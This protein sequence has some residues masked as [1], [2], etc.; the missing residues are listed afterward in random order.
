MAVTAKGV[1]VKKQLTATELAGLEAYGEAMQLAKAGIWDVMAEKVRQGMAALP[2]ATSGGAWDGPRW[3][4]DARKTRP[5]DTPVALFG[6]LQVERLNTAQRNLGFRSMIGVGTDKGVV[7]EVTG[8]PARKAGLQPG[9]RF[10]VIGG[11][12]ILADGAITEAIQAS[13]PGEPVALEVERA[14]KR[15]SLTVTP[16]RRVWDGRS[17]VVDVLTDYAVMASEAGHPALAMAVVDRLRQF[18]KD[19]PGVWNDE[20]MSAL[21]TGHEVMALAGMG[22]VQEAYGLAAR[23]GALKNESVKSDIEYYPGA[24]W[25]LLEDSGKMAYLM[26]IDENKVPKR[27]DRPQAHPFPDLNGVIIPPPTMDGVFVAPPAAGTATPVGDPAA[28]GWQAGPSGT[29]VAFPIPGEEP[30]SK[31]PVDRR[32]GATGTPVGGVIILE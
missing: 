12:A 28:Q 23:S 15:I 25:P 30:V 14:G 6:T 18:Y 5:D 17:A 26:G 11:Q 8:E 1:D 13:Q 10:L 2:L 24:W 32:N 3:L 21:I 16:E 9:D 29:P 7:T 20:Y 27:G 19:N 31:G 22:R 4:R